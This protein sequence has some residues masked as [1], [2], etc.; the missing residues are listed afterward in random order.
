MQKLDLLVI[1]AHPDD[2]ELCC[3]G[4][5]AA[6]IAKGKKVGF[7]ELTRGEL[8]TRGTPELREQ[9]AAAAAKI[10]GLQLRDNLEMADGFFQADRSS[11][12]QV[13]QKIRQYQ[14]EIIITNAVEDRHP[15]H[16]RA[17]ALV[18]EA[19]F[20]SGLRKIET[21]WRGEQ[22]QEWRPRLLFH[23]IQSNYIKPD[24]VID[25]T[26]HWE[27]KLASIK[28]FSSQF[29]NPESSSSDEP[30]TFISTDRFWKFIESRARE[31]GQSIGVTY[32]E[33]FTIERQIGFKSFYDML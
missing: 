17:A 27:T 30:Q 29:Y 9:E 3:S 22:Q 1:T 6:H 13:V 19:F 4:T 14:P 11:I 8:G 12:M 32:G 7:V 10:F 20:L 31:F 16:S 15:D 28:A 5:V 18:K 23:I 26:E 2:A 24:L 33:G 25:I 21:E